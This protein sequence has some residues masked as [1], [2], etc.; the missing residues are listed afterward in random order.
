MTRPIRA[1]DVAPE[2]V[3]WLWPTAAQRE[4]Y[5]LAGRVPR[6]MMTVIGGRPDQ[7][8]GLTA[9]RIAADVSRAGGMVLYS[10]MEDSHGLM[11]APR[12][13]AAGANMANVLLDRFRLPL[14]LDELAWMIRTYEIDLVIVDPVASHLSG[15]INRHSDRIRLV[16]DPLSDLIEKTGTAVILIE[17]VNKRVSRNSDPLSAIGGSGSG[18]PAACRMGYLFGVDEDDPDRRILACVK[19]N[20]SKRPPAMAF[21]LDVAELDGYRDPFPY[22]LFD[23]ECIYDPIRL[24]S[25]PKGEVGRPSDKRAKAAEA[26]R[27]FLLLAWTNG[28]PEEGK[29]PRQEAGQPVP[30]GRVMETMKAFGVSE[31]T[32]RRAKQEMSIVVDPPGGGRNATWRLDLEGE[33]DDE[34]TKML[35]DELD[36]DAS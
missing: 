27:S 13:R 26:L 30:A 34:L 18:L 17:H 20:I 11:T 31:K 33:L 2:V 12:L 35:R 32:L 4:K 25:D 28:L 9:T 23:D 19:S 21:E 6:S 14:Q 24:V 36:D 1:E 29:W 5:N 22:L 10:A 8:K 3:D 15:G 16:T 7:G